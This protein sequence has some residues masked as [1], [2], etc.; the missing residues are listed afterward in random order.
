MISKKM[1]E[2]SRDSSFNM[3][4]AHLTRIDEILYAVAENA[5]ENDYIGWLESLK[6][7]SRE[8]FFLFDDDEFKE[9]TK[10]E[11]S[12]CEA[13]NELN[14]NKDFESKVKSYNA[15]TKYEYFLKK[16]LAE[17]K[18]LMAF[19]KDLKVAISDLG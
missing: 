18:M 8:V 12:C 6:L 13:I 11:N 16:Q 10:L 4:I 17:R 19:S 14:K 7:L 9:N 3:G 5:S 1:A 15:L 2:Y